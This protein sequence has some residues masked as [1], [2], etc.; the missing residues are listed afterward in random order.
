MEA[1]S[2]V[3]VEALM[4]LDTQA[5]AVALMEVVEQKALHPFLASLFAE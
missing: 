3:L 5:L 2:V 4:A 1:E